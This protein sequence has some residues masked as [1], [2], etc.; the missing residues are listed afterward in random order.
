MCQAVLSPNLTK[1]FQWK[2][3]QIAHNRFPCVTL[4]GGLSVNLN[5]LKIEM[6]VDLHAEGELLGEEVLNSSRDEVDFDEL[7]ELAEEEWDTDQILALAAAEEEHCEALREEAKIRQEEQEARRRD[8][9]RQEALQRLQA[10]RSKRLS[11]ENSLQS[12]PATSATVTRSSPYLTSAKTCP[13]KDHRAVP[14][15]AASE[16]GPRRYKLP[17][18]P[19]QGELDSDLFAKQLL[20]SVKHLQH[21]KTAPFAELMCRAMNEKPIPEA[22]LDGIRRAG[23]LPNVHFDDNNSVEIPSEVV[24]RDK[25]GTSNSGGSK[26][27]KCGSVDKRGFD[28]DKKDLSLDRSGGRKLKSGKTTRPDEVGIKRV[29]Q[30]AHEK[31]DPVH[32]RNRVFSE[33]SFHFMVAGELELILQEDIDE[34]EKLVRL[35]FLHMLCYHRQYLGVEDLRDQYDATMKN[36]E[37]GLHSWNDVTVLELQMHSSLTFR[38]TVNARNAEN[39]QVRVDKNDK[40]E[41]KK[42]VSKQFPDGKVVYCLDYNKGSCPFEDHHQGVWNKKNVTKWHICRQCIKLEGNP[43]KSHPEN[44]ENCPCRA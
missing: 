27:N 25:N 23:S 41:V 39:P 28:H 35:R 17:Q 11:L 13:V 9:E 33:L 14:V 7:E 31:L 19:K 16:G 18:P 8:L 30:F 37:R 20:E 43:K 24:T 12:T 44:D 42:E 5:H 40:K 10:V 36:I 2:V 34:C 1:K 32:V 38:A 6:E 26:Q 15:L 22:G 21:G 29:V 3:S 4:L